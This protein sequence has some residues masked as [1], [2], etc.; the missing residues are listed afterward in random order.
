MLSWEHWLDIAMYNV[1]STW[2]CVCCYSYLLNP[3][4]SFNVLIKPTIV[5]VFTVQYMGCEGK[6]LRVTSISGFELF[7]NLLLPFWTWSPEF[8]SAKK[9]IQKCLKFLGLF[10]LIPANERGRKRTKV[11]KAS[12][13]ECNFV[14]CLALL[15]VENVQ[16]NCLGDNGVCVSRTFT[17]IWVRSVCT[18]HLPYQV[19]FWPSA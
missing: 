15:M 11:T 17:S 6:L 14:F 19:E 12:A 18:R 16:K 7:I 3:C 1:T 5:A 9:W 2:N 10:N 13:L 4:N 8:I